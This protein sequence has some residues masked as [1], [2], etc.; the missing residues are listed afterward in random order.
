MQRNTIASLER[1]IDIL[2]YL[3]NHPAGIGV[4]ELGRI[5]DLSRGAVHRVLQTLES[6]GL[7]INDA[8]TQKY[9]LS[10]RVLELSWKLLEEG[11]LTVLSMPHMK[12]LHQ[13]TN[14]TVCL[15]VRIGDGRVCIQQIESTHELRLTMEIGKVYPLYA[16]SCG[17]VLMAY[18]NEEEVDRTLTATE[19]ELLGPN[20]IEREKFKGH[21]AQIR[22][23]GYATSVEER[24]VGAAGM[25]A[26]IFNGQGKVVASVGLY[27]PLLRFANAEERIPLV[28]K[29]A[30]GISRSLGYSKILETV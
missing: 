22:A 3:A 20:V 30:W 2:F 9:R 19:V 4:R 11:N 1:A 10:Y 23:Q 28:K 13:E 17:K 15:H 18:L 27:G 8:V 6:K 24:V 14:E 25:S 7:V 26:P 29:A 16:G 5:L 21:L 12:E